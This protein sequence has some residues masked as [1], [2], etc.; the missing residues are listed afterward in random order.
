MSLTVK[1]FSPYHQ[2][3]AKTLVFSVISEL[4]LELLQSQQLDQ[5]QSISVFQ[6]IPQPT[7]AYTQSPIEH[8][9]D[10]DTL[11]SISNLFQT[12]AQN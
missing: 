10:S 7:Q 3:L 1:Q 6:S 4:E 11:T 5:Q 8:Q 2:R 12:F 9:S